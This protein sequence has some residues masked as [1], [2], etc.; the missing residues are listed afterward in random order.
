MGL[1]SQS[2]QVG[3]GSGKSSSGKGGSGLPKAVV[4]LLA[5]GGVAVGGWFGW[6]MLK[7]G[8]NMA[9]AKN[10]HG[11]QQASNT[12]ST[13]GGGS[14]TDETSTPAMKSG[15]NEST[16]SSS[17]I[18]P[19]PAQTNNDASHDEAQS[20]E[21]LRLFPTGTQNADHGADASTPVEDEKTS[22]TPLVQTPPERE[23][24]P[25]RTTQQPPRTNWSDPGAV[26]PT[27]VLNDAPRTVAAQIQSANDAIND[28]DL[29]MAREHYYR[30]LD[31]P[32]ATEAN[33]ELARTQ[34]Q[35]LNDTIL[36]SPRKFPGEP[37][38][39]QYVVDGNDFAL[40]QIVKKLSLPIDYRLIARVNKMRNPDIIRR[41]QKL[42]IIRGPFHAEVIKS[43]FRV[44]IYS[45]DPDNRQGWRYVRSFPVG[46]GEHGSTP[47]GRF[48]VKLNSK[49]V[50]P[51]WI[52]PRTGERFT[53]DNPENPIGEYWIGL[54]GLGESEHETGY[55]L[56]GT[57]DP[58]SIGQEKSMGCVR[59]RDDDIAFVYE[60]LSEKVSIVNIID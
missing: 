27:A 59:M 29:L 55:G 34:I 38:T 15:A 33:C 10:D 53:A 54:Q 47:S 42:K 36:F 58:D 51:Y 43:K 46:L 19:R 23:Q 18:D 4:A 1:P 25:P 49:L 41:D 2:K 12:E 28:G 45:G 50:D 11:L 39:E 32:A 44:D 52:N 24:T 57:V 17:H 60:L 40:S 16:G 26:K 20:D 56:H 5:C 3:W 22:Q 21:A 14:G 35:T 13:H 48:V 30:L 7:P 6:T 37:M 9:N 31:N 8:P